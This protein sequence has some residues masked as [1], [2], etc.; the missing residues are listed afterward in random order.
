MGFE[1]MGRDP[2][3]VAPDLVQQHVARDHLAAGAEQV[4]E[5]GGLLFG[6]PHL[7]LVVRVGE[8]LGARPEIIRADGKHRVFALLVL[9]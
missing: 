9:A 5:D 4:F 3:V 8:Q 1:R 2:R 6:E 7:L